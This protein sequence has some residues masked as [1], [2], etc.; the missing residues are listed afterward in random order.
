MLLL[1]VLIIKRK[2]RCPIS[3]HDEQVALFDWAKIYSKEIPELKTMF[4]IPNQGGVGRSS[5]VRGVKMVKEGLKSGVPDIFLPVARGDFHG[6]F[7]EMK[8]GKGRV[9]K[10]QKYWLNSLTLAGYLC[11]VCFD[12]ESAKDAVLDYVSGNLDLEGFFAGPPMS[13]N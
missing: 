9:S 13:L 1:F 12:F 2:E 8:F 5:I 11:V 4:A 10:E 6:L 7:L 3:E